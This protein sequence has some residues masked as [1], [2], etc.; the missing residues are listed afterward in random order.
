[1]RYSDFE[2]MV[3]R[4]AG[5]V[6]GEFRRGV[7]G[8]E[9]S[10]ATMP[11]PERADVFTLGE[12][13]PDPA[14]EAPTPGLVRS[15][16]VLYHGSFRALASQ[17]PDFDWRTE[18]WETLTHELRHHLEWQA[19][20][21]ALEAFDRAAEHN[22]ARHDGE[23]FDPLFFLDGERLEG[24]AWQVDDDVFIDRI[25]RRLPTLVAFA[26]RGRDYE[27]AVPPEM[28]LPCFLTVEGVVEPPPG[29]LV[30]VLRQRP[31]L[32]ALFRPKAATR[33][34]VPARE[35]TKGP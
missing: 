12:C 1:M 16:I 13:I 4:L 3:R 8:I 32:G 5:E 11:H 20:T 18:A 31:G 9:V 14:A 27:V 17:D 24:D 26:W 23:R 28:R 35:I 19:R 7:G 10:P 34:V 29:D 22:F 30:L 15:R 2:S 6:P 33:A 21:E 25:V